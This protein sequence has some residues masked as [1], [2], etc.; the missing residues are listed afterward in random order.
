MGYTGSSTAINYAV[1][2]TCTGCIPA[3]ANFGIANA[4]ILDG[5][6]TVITGTIFIARS[7][8]TTTRFGNN[9]VAANDGSYTFQWSGNDLIVTEDNDD[10]TDSALNGTTFYWYR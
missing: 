9:A 2:T 8:I 6:V 3:S 7:G 4:G 5:G 1:T 10:A